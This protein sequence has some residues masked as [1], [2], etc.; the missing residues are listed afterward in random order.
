MVV[1]TEDDKKI[2]YA[3]GPY[4]GAEGNTP[5]HLASLALTKKIRNFRHGAAFSRHNRSKR[6]QLALHQPLVLAVPAL[7]IG[8]IS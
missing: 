4:V 2:R 7:P 1:E 6:I 8:N 5:T 3:F